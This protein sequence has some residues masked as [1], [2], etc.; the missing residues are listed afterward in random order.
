MSVTLQLLVTWVMM[1][2]P[3]PAD[4]DEL[5]EERDSDIG[6]LQRV[7]TCLDSIR[8][9]AGKLDSEA[10]DIAVPAIAGVNPKTGRLAVVT[11]HELASCTGTENSRLGIITGRG[12]AVG[13][14]LT[15][16][17]PDICM[18]MEEHPRAVKRAWKHLSGLRKQGFTP[19]KNLV[20]GLVEEA[21]GIRMHWPLVKL[22][23]PLAG[24]LVYAP[25]SE[26]PSR[27][28]VTWLI[29]PNQTRSYR[30]GSIAVKRGGCEELSGDSD[31]C[32][33][34]ALYEYA[35]F[36]SVVLTPNKKRLVILL[37]IADGTHCGIDVAKVLS[38]TLPKG[39]RLKP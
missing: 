31:R 5:W 19:S 25:T 27:R 34:Y 17:G 14:S 6:V 39:V 33:S 38:Y 9:G 8:P 21:G 24:W 18:D 35:T 11:A 29:S 16:L 23:G 13:K 2:P 32:E 15:L 4:L 7:D 12:K 37:S 3:I 26:P 28:L 10:C 30:L 36:V 1:V 22:A 20:A